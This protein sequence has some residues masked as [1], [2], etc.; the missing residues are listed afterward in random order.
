[1]S[2]FRQEFWREGRWVPFALVVGAAL[3]AVAVGLTVWQA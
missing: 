3:L 2:I 1:M